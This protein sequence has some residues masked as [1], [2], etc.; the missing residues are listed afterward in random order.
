MSKYYTALVSSE[1]LDAIRSDFKII[2]KADSLAQARSGAANRV[3]TVERAT[4]QEIF[5]AGRNGNVVLDLSDSTTYEDQQPLPGFEPEEPA[6]GHAA[7]PV[8]AGETAS[9]SAPAWLPKKGDPVSQ[10]TGD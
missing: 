4:D 3:I 2:I 8:L 1:G 9:G 10:S 6:A 7:T 5:E